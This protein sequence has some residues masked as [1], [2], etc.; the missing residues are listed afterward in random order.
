MSPVS[1]WPMRWYCHQQGDP[2]LLRDTSL[3]CVCAEPFPLQTS[4]GVRSTGGPTL[5]FTPGPLPLRECEPWRRATSPVLLLPS[6]S[7]GQG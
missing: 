2:T 1:S 7:Q 3:S 5:C 6:L 4:P